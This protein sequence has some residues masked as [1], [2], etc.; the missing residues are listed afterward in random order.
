MS[1][2][3]ERSRTAPGSWSLDGFEHD[4]LL[5]AGDAE[6]VARVGEFVTEGLERDEPVLVVVVPRKIELLRRA[7]GPDGERV[8]FADMAAIG[9]NP[10][11][12]IPVWR[13]FIATRALEGTRVR[14]VGEPIWAGRPDAELVE[15]QRH[16]ELINLAFAGA[17]GRIL[18][19]YDV[20]A[21]APS[22]VREAFRSH[23]AV[24]RAGVRG[25]SPAWEGLDAISGEFAHALPPRARDA[26]E[27]AISMESLDQVR[28]FVR[29]HGARLGLREPRVED[30]VL[31]V[32]E[33]ATNSVRH[34]GGTG[35]VAIWPEEGAVVCEV[36]DGGRI[37]DPLA[38]RARPASSQEGRIGLWL[39]HQ[40]CDL[41]Q[42]RSSPDGTVVRLRVDRG[43]GR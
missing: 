42:V 5:Y 1:T 18:C 23:P 8:T 9:R 38:G 4:A 29:A 3:F 39:V 17:P 37:R 12:I 22:V 31:A 11:R 28:S 15:S 30:L 40:L 33:L 21:L 43:V 20:D 24:V 7:L 34:G 27:T 13:D 19:P 14:G 35:S 41:V 6:F 26:V 32:N 25:P 36:R 2:V 16:E 10:S